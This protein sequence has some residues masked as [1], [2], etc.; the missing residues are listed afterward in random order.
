MQRYILLPDAGTTSNRAILFN[1]A[2]EIVCDF[3]IK[4]AI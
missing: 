3:Q 2:G 1:H 4:A